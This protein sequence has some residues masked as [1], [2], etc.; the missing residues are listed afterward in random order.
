LAA[1]PGGVLVV[2]FANR[3][4]APLIFFHMTGDA[5]HPDGKPHQA[6]VMLVMLYKSTLERIADKFKD[7]PITADAAFQQA[8]AGPNAIEQLRHLLENLTEAVKHGG[9]L[10]TALTRLNEA[11]LIADKTVADKI[12][13][14]FKAD[15]KTQSPFLST[16]GVGKLLNTLLGG[17]RK[18][19]LT[20]ME[21]LTN[22]LKA[23]DT[24]VALKPKPAI[25][26]AGAFPSFSLQFELDVPSVTLSELFHQMIGAH[27]V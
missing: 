2:H 13:A 5:T 27:S 17:L 18:A 11:G 16:V 8:A 6:T 26:F 24:Y 1:L 15:E 14:T 9:S 22:A 7:D 19:A 23:I 12:E 3:K 4:N 21:I 25:G 10:Q 20:L